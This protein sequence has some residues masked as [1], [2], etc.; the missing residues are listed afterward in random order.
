MHDT[1]ISDIIEMFKLTYTY[2]Q[3]EKLKFLPPIK[4]SFFKPLFPTTTKIKQIKQ[5]NPTI[6]SSSTLHAVPLVSVEN[7]ETCV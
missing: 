6:F 4:P 3:E 5:P 1:V 7:D 2:L